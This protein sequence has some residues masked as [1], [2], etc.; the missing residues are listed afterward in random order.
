MFIM[1]F[2][3]SCLKMRP[4]ESVNAMKQTCVIFILAFLPDSKQK[5]TD[6]TAKTLKYRFLHRIS[7]YK[8]ASACKLLNII[9]LSLCHEMVSLDC[10]A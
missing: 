7:L 3:G 10:N 2:H 8:M 4:P 5:C 9:I 6:N 1:H